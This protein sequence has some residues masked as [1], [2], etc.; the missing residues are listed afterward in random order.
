MKAAIAA[1]ALSAVAVAASI[2]AAQAHAAVTVGIETPAFGI[3]FGAPY[4]TLAPVYPAPVY[5]PAPVYAPAPPG[6][7]VPPRVVVRPP[8]V[9]PVVY[10]YGPPVVKHH[11][12]AHRDAYRVIVPSGYAYGRY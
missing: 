7:Y 9:Y 11:K 2:G 6:V 3:R 10:P 1:V 8:V 4:V 5:V 12:R